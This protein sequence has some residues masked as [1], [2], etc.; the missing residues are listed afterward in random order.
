M[1]VEVFGGLEGR[2]QAGVR[3]AQALED[4]VRTDYTVRFLIIV[5]ARIVDVDTE[6]ELDNP[7]VVVALAQSVLR[8]QPQKGLS[9]L[10]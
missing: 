4:L 7:I 5:L 2:L 6:Y 10:L 8:H 1:E 9:V 3:G